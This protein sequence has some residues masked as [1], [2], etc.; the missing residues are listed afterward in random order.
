MFSKVLKFNY[1]FILACF[2]AVVE[3]PEED[4]G[5]LPPEHGLQAQVLPIMFLNILFR[6]AGKCR[7]FVYFIYFAAF[8]SLTSRQEA[9]VKTALE[10][11]FEKYT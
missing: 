3:H 2:Q 8:S 5:L 4:E 7:F 11:E 10:P 9:A 6:H 1:Y